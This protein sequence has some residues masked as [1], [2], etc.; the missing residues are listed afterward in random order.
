MNFTAAGCMH[1]TEAAS[2]IS[3]FVVYSAVGDISTNLMYPMPYTSVLSISSSSLMPEIISWLALWYSICDVCK[4][5]HSQKYCTPHTT[6]PTRQRIVMGQ[7]RNPVF[8]LSKV[9]LSEPKCLVRT[10]PCSSVPFKL[11]VPD[12]V[13]QLQRPSQPSQPHRPTLTS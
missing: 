8:Y 4:F 13:L 5:L 11:G 10:V 2:L 12:F 7:I 9:P 1:S 6:K 3:P